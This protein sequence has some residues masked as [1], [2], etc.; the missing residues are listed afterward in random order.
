MFRTRTLGVYQGFQA[1]ILLFSFALFWSTLAIFALFY[2]RSG[3]IDLERYAVC[4]GLLLVALFY[5]AIKID[6]NKNNLLQ[7]GFYQAN[8]AAFNAAMRVAALWLFYIFLSRNDT[9]SRF[10]LCGFTVGLYG[11]LV[12]LHRYLPPILTSMSFRGQREQ[13]TLLIG[14]HDRAQSII[15]WLERKEKLGLRPIGWIPDLPDSPSVKGLPVLGL[16]TDFERIITEHRIGLVILLD[17]FKSDAQ[18]TQIATYCE[19]I[20][21]RL[22]IVNDIEERIGQSTVF[23]RDDDFSFVALRTEPLENPFNRLVKR[24]VDLLVAVIAV[25]IVLPIPTLIVWLSHR[26]QSPGPLIYRQKRAGF[27]NEMF[28]LFKFRT[29]HVAHGQEAKQA[30]QHDSRIFPLGTL[31]RRFSIDELPQFINVLLGDMSVVGPRPHMPEHNTSFAKLLNNYH[32]RAFVK[33]GI[34][35]L[36]QVRGFRGETKTDKDLL[37]RIESDIHYIE[38][39]SLAM[40][41]MIILR[42]VTQVLFPPRTA[43]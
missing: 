15:P 7:P 12:V 29:M 18:L 9:I 42:T 32:V 4:C 39:W 20:G 25:F 38:N 31:F 21:I 10:F 19:N 3:F 17:L 16:P 40:D 27:Q 28:M 13:R 8:S 14:S 6:L 22:L 43:Y 36:A 1:C 2:D 35:G 5:S 37:A 11:C 33:P 41:V 24:I 23:V 34:T 26:L 30:T